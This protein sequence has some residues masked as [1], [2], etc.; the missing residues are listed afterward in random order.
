MT[1]AAHPVRATVAIPEVVF[2]RLTVGATGA[3][4]E[5]KGWG[6]TSCTRDSAGTYTLQL[7]KQYAHLVGVSIT[8]LHSA[9]EDITFQLIS[10]D[11][12][13]AT[14]AS[15]T[16]VVECKK[17]A[18]ATDPAENSVVLFTFFFS[19]SKGVGIGPDRA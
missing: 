6:I 3:V 12:D 1:R 7:D 2:G 10:E 19:N 8:E 15:R 9:G 4:S 13:N 5:F 16:I 18:A 11:V 14:A 17:A